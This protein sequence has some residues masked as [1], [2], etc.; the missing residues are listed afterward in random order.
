MWIP[1][2]IVTLFAASFVVIFLPV[3]LIE[4]SLSMDTLNAN[5]LLSG[6][7]SW[8]IVG[9]FGLFGLM[10]SLWTVYIQVVIAQYPVEK[11]YF[12]SPRGICAYTHDVII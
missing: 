4:Y 12:G 7:F 10:L 5:E 2:I 6:F 1:R 8:R 11:Y 9:V 3:A